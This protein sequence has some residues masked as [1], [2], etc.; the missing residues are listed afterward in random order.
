LLDDATERGILLAEPHHPAVADRH[1]LVRALVGP[2]R[3]GQL[4]G[5]VVDLLRADAAHQAGDPFRAERDAPRQSD[6]QQRFENRPG[7]D[8]AGSVM[9]PGAEVVL[10]EVRRRIDFD[11]SVPV[12]RGAALIGVCHSHHRSEGPCQAVDRQP[13]VG[14]GGGDPSGGLITIR[15]TCSGLLIRTRLRG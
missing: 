12:G 4:R 14:R 11:A 3:A 10:V 1:D 13:A 2:V 9:F 6:E 5:Q 15:R 8:P 7:A